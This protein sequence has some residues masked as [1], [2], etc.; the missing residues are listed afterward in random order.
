MATVQVAQP[1]TS[2]TSPALAAAAAKLPA[3]PGGGAVVTPWTQNFDPNASFKG[4]QPPFQFQPARPDEAPNGTYTVRPGKTDPRGHTED[5]EGG[6]W[7][8]ANKKPVPADVV[9]DYN[10]AANSTTVPGQPNSQAGS[11]SGNSSSPLVNDADRAK[12]LDQYRTGID[13]GQG[14]YDSILNPRDAGG[15]PINDPNARN[16]FDPVTGRQVTT[17][18]VDDPRRVQATAVNAPDKPITV[19][20][21]APGAIKTTDAVAAGAINPA[22]LTP[23]QRLQAATQ[24]ATQVQGTTL[25]TSQSDDSRAAATAAL[26]ELQATA[27]GQGQ[28]QV[29]SDAQLKLDLAKVSGAAQGLARGA[30]GS[31]RKGAL[32]QG[33][34][35]AGEQGAQAV[36]ANAAK[37][38]EVALAAQQTVGTQAQGNRAQDLAQATKRA[39]L[40]AQQRTLQA[41][42][43][44]ARAAGDAGRAQEITTKLADLDQQVQALNAGATNAANEAAAGRTT[45]VSL[46][47]SQAKN[48]AQEGGANRIADTSKTNAGFINT[49][50]ENDAAR[51]LAAATTTAGLKTDVDKTNVANQTQVDTANADRQQRTDVG[52]ADRNL[53]AGIA[54]NS[55]ALAANVAGSQQ[56]VAQADLRMRAQQAIEASA[57]GLL[58]ENERQNQLAIAR[59]QLAIARAK[60]DREGEQSWFDK[61]SALV[62]TAAT[63]A[64][65]VA[66]VAVA[67]S[68]PR[69]KT[70][71]KKISDKDLGELAQAL[72]DSA[73]TWEY[74]GDMAPDLPEGRHAGGMTDAI[75]ATKLGRALVTKRPDGF[76]QM[77][78][79]Q[80]AAL[81]AAHNITEKK[82]SVA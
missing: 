31:E 66:P 77:D 14:V 13:K 30:R 6:Y 47:N 75:K 34:L 41:Q 73:S 79:G 24:A 22:L 17:T 1:T 48:T 71:I 52:N 78:Y 27:Q 80:M 57:K 37:N 9:T 44:A 4:Y 61:I 19:T 3:A 82:R 45:T 51:R 69:L 63:V 74:R 55:G 21:S 32:I 64:K 46:A 53:Q 72:R 33:Q 67:A 26:K 68:D 8:D 23:A 28:A 20:A 59:E 2:G 65:V 76:E 7:F 54:N 42:L 81:L 39:D 11:G 62:T 60:G 10:N 50:G 56:D 25:D 38:A 29:R 43:D 36:A 70:N 49:A 16:T 5:D 12:A 58:D 18:L 15:M 40:E 35:T